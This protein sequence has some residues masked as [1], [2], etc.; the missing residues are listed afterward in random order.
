MLGVVVLCVFWALAILVRRLARVAAKPLPDE[1][2]RR[3]VEQVSSYVVWIIGTLV[4][5]NAAGMNLETMPRL[6]GSAGSQSV[7]R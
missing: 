5:F 3:L 7:S 2:A 1:T 4:T 6:L